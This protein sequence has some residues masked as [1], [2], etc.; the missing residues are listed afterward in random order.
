MSCLGVHFALTPEDA[1]ALRTIPN[2]KDR[3]FRLQE[4]LEPRYFE[5][6][7]YIAE[8]DKSWDA[9][10]R[11]LSDGQ[12]SWSGG[13][14]PLNHTVLA[15]ELLYTDSDYIMSLKTPDQVKEISSALDTLTE[16]EFSRRYYQIDS[17]SYGL[18]P[19]AQ[20]FEYTWEW[21]QGVRELY[22]RA[23]QEGR[24]VLFTADQ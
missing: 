17:D 22:R 12:L 4:E 14:F 18:T 2:E 7:T 3:L 23:A 19:S 24:F 8:S 10:H 16:E 21:F 15:G 11:V 5:A 13:K 6:A 1:E 9:M 20:D